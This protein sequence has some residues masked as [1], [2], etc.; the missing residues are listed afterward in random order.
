M[1]AR[2]LRPVYDALD[3]SD[4]TLAL[5]ECDRLLRKH[6]NHYS[7][8]ALKTFV[9]AKSGEVAE[10]T[11]LG[12]SLLDTPP[13]L[14]SPHVQ[15]GLS[16]AYRVLGRPTDEIAVYTAALA[17]TP[18]SET[19][20][21]KIYMAAAR[22]RLFKEQHLAAVELT[23][24][25]KD[26][27]YGWWLVT[28]LLL[29]A[30]A[31]ADAALGRVQIALA[32][33]M[34]EKVLASGQLTTLEELR[35]YLDVLDAQDKHAD[36]LRVLGADANL[37]AMVLRDPDLV[38]RRIGLLLRTGAHAAAASAA[39]E[40]L[41]A[42]DNWADYVHYI[43]TLLGQP[44]GSPDRE[45]LAAAICANLA[46]WAAIPGRARGATLARAALSVSMPDGAAAGPPGENIWAYVDAFQ[47]KAICY[48]D[49]MQ[50][51]VRHVQEAA[52]GD[53]RAAVLA[54]H[55]ERLCA[56]LDTARKG[57]GQGEAAAQTWLSLEKIR[58]L[59]QA[60]RGETNPAAWVS[61][62]EPLLAFGL[63]SKDAREKRPA[64]SDIVLVACMRIVLAAFLAHGAAP[65]RSRLAPALFKAVCVLEAGIRLNDNAPLLK[66]YAI[67]LYL[68]LS[69]YDRARVIYATLSVKHIQHDT[70]AHFI[71]GQGIALGCHVPDLDLC[72]DGVSFYDL[73]TAKIPRE[74]EMA[75]QR[76][77]YSNVQDFLEFQ[78][79]LARSLQRECTHRLALRAEVIAHGGGKDMLDNWTAADAASIG[80]SEK[81]LAALHDNRDLAAMGLLTPPDMLPWNL[82]VATRPAPLP[83][84]AWIQAFSLVPQV[85]H[86]IVTADVDAV[87]VK[88][89]ELAA[90][91]A[92][93]GDSLST[94]DA[95]L[96]RGIVV[97]ADL[98]SQA[99]AKQEAVTG[100]LDELVELVGSN[101]PDSQLEIDSAETMGDMAMGNIRRSAMAAELFTYALALKHALAAQRLPAAQA[102]GT[103]LAQLRKTGLQS[104]NAF[105]G[106]A[107]KCARAQI[108]AHWMGPDNALFAGVAQYIAA[109]QKQ[110]AA[111]AAKAC[112]ASW[113]RSAKGLRAQWEQLS[114]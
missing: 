107:D 18:G 72:Y 94:H 43:D 93:T 58:F 27:K 102:V 61:G 95:A 104:A 42:R 33:R 87:E 51:I 101:I 69:C 64:C 31:P 6:P 19:L 3:R 46:R 20:R 47:H 21:C 53:A 32:E 111:S 7:A 39:V 105:R 89:R 60:L 57:A 98:Y 103:A 68:L 2:Q 70:I 54:C 63:E 88:A 76:G 49:I 77:T 1:E 106:W 35:I 10:A 9:L 83:G 12:Q 110:A 81:S 8:R 73:A 90:V 84:T 78:E 15:Q 13:A 4:L 16:L 67:R 99:S 109:S 96:L 11:A 36:M 80:H 52:P 30:K 113:L 66:L 45:A 74:L 75:Y 85:M 56:R 82:E 114:L 44:A 23:K 38:T 112:A 37:A 14:A 97:I 34:A 55:E 108:D 29:Q 92:D 24:Q 22:N 17:S 62:V 48:S 40:A 79:N 5:R 65:D 25:F 28:S 26:P 41:D 50:F 91:I 100:R 86:H 71:V 59:L